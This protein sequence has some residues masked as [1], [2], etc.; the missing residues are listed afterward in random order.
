MILS[1]RVLPSS[2][3]AALLL[4]GVALATPRQS[5]AQEPQ[6]QQQS[7]SATSQ[8]PTGAHTAGPKQLQTIQVVGLRASQMRSI[9]L[10]RAAPNLQDSITAVN[11]GQLPDITIADSIQRISGVQVDRT[12]GEGGAVSINGLPQVLTTLNGDAFLSAANVDSN[13]PNYESLPSE[14]FAGVDV[15]K[16]P[17]GNMTYSGISGTINLRTRHPWD[18][19]FGWTT[20]ATI[21]AERGSVSKETKPDVSALLGYNANGRWGAL[22]TVSYSDLVHNY[23][24]DQVR[25]GG[26]AGENSSAA[27]VPSQGYLQAYGNHP[28]PSQIVLL[29]DGGVDVNGDGKSNGAF[30]APG[31]FYASDQQNQP[32]RTGINASF[33]TALGD[34]F[35]LTADGFFTTQTA[36]TTQVGIR[37][38]PPSQG[39]ETTLPLAARDTGV[40]LHNPLNEPGLQTGNWNQNLFTTQAY[41]QYFGDIMSSTEY[42][43]TSGVSHNY[44]LALDYDDGGPFTGDARFISA[45]ASQL[46]SEMFFQTTVSDGSGWPNTLLP[47]VSLPPTVYPVPGGAEPFNSNGFPLFAFATQVDWRGQ[48]PVVTNPPD[49]ASKLADQSTYRVKGIYADGSWQNSAMNI[50]RLDGHYKFGNDL[51]VDFGARNSIRSASD[52]D[53]VETAP[54]YAGTGAT[55]PAGCM[56]RYTTADTVVN[57]GG[58]DGGCAAGNSVGFYRGNVYTGPLSGLPALISDHIAN[59]QQP[60]DAI[61]TNAISLDPDYSTPKK[62][63]LGFYG[64]LYPGAVKDFDPAASWDVLLKTRT[65]YG[66]LNFSGDLAGHDVSGNLGARVVKTHLGVTQYIDGKDPGYGDRAL[67][68]GST[69]TNQSYLDI[70]PAFNAAVHLTDNLIWRLAASKNMMPL[71]LDEWGGGFQPSYEF[72]ILPNGSSIFAVNGADSGGNPNLKPWRSTNYNTSIEYY[73]G[74]HSLLSFNLFRIRVASFVENSSITNCALPDEDG[75]VRGRCVPVSLPI[76]GQGAILHGAEFDWKQSLAALPSVLPGFVPSFISTFLSDT[77]FEVNGTYSPSDSGKTDLAGNAVPFPDNSKK[78]GNIILWFQNDRIQARIAENYRS[79]TAVASNMLGVNGLEEYQAGA[80]YVDA[81]VAY[82]INPHLQLF[83]QGNNLGDTRQQFYFT[84]PDQKYV[85][86]LSERAYFVGLHGKW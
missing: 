20:T 59:I 23:A 51:S 30:Y 40:V 50:V 8:N 63:P 29:P 78:S 37:T 66:Q 58:V 48:L 83:V 32:K 56:V 84:W 47:G 21:Q 19:P 73:M 39:A 1:R 62:D 43:T 68:A 57:G 22:I 35:T 9:Q 55:D 34:A 52:F 5:L 44:H 82:Q 71:T 11:I 36:Y 2:I 80:T 24:F 42:Q 77:G 14:L 81:S 67:V 69:R 65:L 54:I 25:T 26:L 12:A 17:R 33:Q 76:Q 75:V 15:I 46:E 79:R 41:A 74:N 49:V 45:S 64:Q 4:G 53:F 72:T 28:L 61:G 38:L 13:Q 85:V 27:N 18:L 60:G 86:N 70:L 7:S 3:A 6:P 10:K 31:R 16:S